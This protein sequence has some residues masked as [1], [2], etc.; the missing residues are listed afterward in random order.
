MLI[1]L[2]FL[3]DIT[4]V[5]FVDTVY[6]QGIGIVMGTNCA[7]LIA[8]I[9]LCFYESQFTTKIKKIPS[10]Q[11][12][13]ET[14]SD[15]WTIFWL[16]TATTSIFGLKIYILQNFLWTQQI[17]ILKNVCFLILVFKSIMPNLILI[18]HKRDGFSFTIVN[19][20]F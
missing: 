17:L 12:L 4:F 14:P 16:L 20:S 7:P 11:H 15:I 6:R 9:S 13:V 5:R 8:D 3:L 1:T 18:Y 2:E 19:H 10:Q